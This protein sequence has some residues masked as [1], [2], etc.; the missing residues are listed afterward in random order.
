MTMLSPLRT[1]T[2]PSASLASL[3]VS[4]TIG[5]DPTWAVTL[6]IILLFS[7][8]ALVSRRLARSPELSNE[9]PVQPGSR[10][11]QRV[12]VTSG[13]G[14]LSGRGIGSESS[15]LG[16]DRL[17]CGRRLLLLSLQT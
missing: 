3:P 11:V 1:V 2:A 8:P 14:E 16:P 4:M 13:T 5:D 6:C 17:R 7:K 15:G 9:A 12:V 10:W